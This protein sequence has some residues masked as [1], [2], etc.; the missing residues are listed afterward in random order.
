M[1]SKPF[2]A[3]PL[4]EVFRTL[5][6]VPEGLSNEEAHK[7]N[8]E[9]GLN[10]LKESKKTSAI[11]IF[12]S[13]FK[14]SLVI[15]LG[16]ATIVLAYLGFTE[17][18]FTNLIEAG[19]IAIIILFN[20]IFGFL[21]D[22]K[23]EKSIQLLKKM[24]S[25]KNIVLRNKQL[26][27][28]DSKEITIGD[29][30]I[31][32]EGDI[33][34]A[35]ARLIEAV[36][37]ETD[38]SSLTGESSPVKKETGIIPEKTV[39]A[40]RSNSVF[41][42]SR[43]IKGHGK[44][45]VTSI[46]TETELGKIAEA[47]E[48]IETKTSPFQAELG[49]LGKKISIGIIVIIIIIAAVQLAI[50][51]DSTIIQIFIMAIALAVAA[52]PEGLPAVITV[53]LALNTRKLL[54]KN[55]LVR[56]L[57]VIE[58]LGS[59]DLICSD[60]TG[61]LTQGKM[62]VT[63]TFVGL[64][65]KTIPEWERQSL[66]QKE[67]QLF[68]NALVHCNN[69]KI[70]DK[71]LSGDYTEKAL[72]EFAVQ[73][74]SEWQKKQ[75]MYPR[76][77]E[78]SFS[79]ET[80]R[81]I[82]LN[83]LEKENCLLAKGAT[84]KIME[85]CSHYFENGKK[86]PLT[87]KAAEQIVFNEEQMAEQA[88]RVLALAAKPT[89]EK[90]I[91]P[92]KMVFLGLVGLSDPIRHGV[93]QAIDECRE[94]GIQVKMIT[95]DKAITA[96]SI[97]VQLGLDSSAVTGR[98]IDE[99][100]EKELEEKIIN[101]NVFARVEPR[102]K[103]TILSVLQKKGHVVAMTGDGVNDAPAL[104]K[105]D[106]GIAMGIRGTDVAKQSAELVLLDDNFLSIVEAIKLGRT[107]F[108]NIRKFVNYLLTSNFAEVF[109][110]FFAS[111]AGFLPLTAGQL[112]LIN[113]FTDGPPAVAIGM[114]PPTEGIMK[115]KPKPKKE[116]VLNRRLS[117]LIIS[118]GSQLTII[119]LIVIFAGLWLGGEK[120]ASTMA[121][122]GFI[123]FELNR[124]AAIRKSEGTPFFSNKWLTLAMSFSIIFAL[125]LVYSPLNKLI[126]LVPLGIEHWAVL[127]AGLAIGWFSGQWITKKIVSITPE[128]AV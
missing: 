64:K 1:N 57:S 71:K 34:P 101:S 19:L 110:I 11:T 88:L 106:V 84:E 121:F 115:Q 15:I 114:D 6:S 58:D 117:Y 61:T 94:A 105:A 63:K 125:V 36:D 75:K 78:E 81:M 54:E 72:L 108:G 119:I 37:F 120:I 35:E 48:A 53:S 104:K 113:I 4:K 9:F 50:N 10:E 7:R 116:G 23:A 79:H 112:L 42:A 100:S 39:L 86:I 103:V 82:V 13:Q 102:H 76:I 83:K 21:Q 65:E 49:E 73:F 43:I 59:V 47:V 80:K 3:L 40:E 44:A 26:V 20:S 45:I 5:N 93:K 99:L 29:I 90:K 85:L 118:I 2:F 27:E 32:E 89:Q 92:E 31:L 66:S 128:N 62:A 68:W 126:G 77:K 98:E 28:I 107:S 16:I 30:I 24:A 96:Q 51:T 87:K 12:L 14:N 70:V 109:G 52:I 17:N 69:A 97:A 25:P 56:K 124:I 18:D 41:T 38:E 122:T 127:L 123:L 22:F 60:K 46:G 55:T 33:V 67:N 8:K 91:V 95:G 74:D 111:L